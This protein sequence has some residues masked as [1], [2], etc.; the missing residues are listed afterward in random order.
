[1]EDQRRRFLG[2]Y[3]VYAVTKASGGVSVE[4]HALAMERM[5]QRPAL[6]PMTWLAVLCEWQR[7]WARTEKLGDLAAI[8]E[9]QTGSSG[10]AR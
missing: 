7:D 2:G 10:V 1:M 9:E 3:E 8:L 6:T 5:I 4:A